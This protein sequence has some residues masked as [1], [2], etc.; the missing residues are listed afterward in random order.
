[1]DQRSGVVRMRLCLTLC[2]RLDRVDRVQVIASPVE[3]E[4][5]WQRGIA[6]KVRGLSCCSV[7]SYLRH[8]SLLP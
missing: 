8:S 1:M 3:A 7:T 5:Q 6:Y 4:G 2:C